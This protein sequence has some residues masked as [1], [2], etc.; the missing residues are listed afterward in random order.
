M[1]TNNTEN[2][3]NQNKELISQLIKIY[4]GPLLIT[5]KELT[6]VYKNKLFDDLFNTVTA[7]DSIPEL[8]DIKPS[9]TKITQNYFSEKLKMIIKLSP[10][11]LEEELEGFLITLENA[12]EKPAGE[13]SRLTI[14]AIAHDLNNIFTNIINSI[15]LLKH[16]E[17]QVISKAKLLGIIEN[18]SNR[19]LDIISSVLKKSTETNTFKSQIDMNSLLEEISVSFKLFLPDRIKLTTEIQ[20]GLP[21]ILG[22]YTDLY[23]SIYNLL[24]NS[25]EAILGN[26]EIKLA[27]TQCLPVDAD[28][29]SYKAQ[30]MLFVRIID[31][32][33]GIDETHLDK[34]FN[35][36]FS[37]RDKD[38][39][40]GIG[41]N[42]VKSI[43]EKHNGKIKVESIKGTGTT[44]EISLPV[45]EQSKSIII[46]EPKKILIAEDEDTLRELLKDLFESHGLQVSAVKDG[47]EV[48]EAV[49]NF[50]YFDALIIDKKMPNMDGLECILELH[51]L[52]LKIPIILATGS[53]GENLHELESEYKINVALRKPYKFDDL[54]HL[55]NKVTS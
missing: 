8:L 33:H 48:I 36:S 53:T 5:N 10:I 54:L 2:K 51:N 50:P 35:P 19:A 15:D 25:K 42:N 16:S 40:S 7:N 41:L 43:I 4:N 52:G 32:G 47:L 39:V 20:Y 44:F 23:R 31:T 21:K 30:R 3:L 46:D 37:T 29:S 24:I 34:I 1:I 13:P 28:D 11:V 6:I 27:A 55:V 14:R 38:L 17:N 26:G 12:H 22:N 9:I 49:K 18:S 45:L